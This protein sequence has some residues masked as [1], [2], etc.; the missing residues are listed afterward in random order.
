MK[1]GVL[2]T[3]PDTKRVLLVED[4]DADA[5]LVGEYLLVADQNYELERCETL[6]AGRDVVRNQDIDVILFDL[7]LPDASQDESLE[8]ISVF[9]DYA[10]LVV[11]TGHAET[12]T[13]LEAMQCGAEEFLDKDL[14]GADLLARTIEHAIE[15]HEMRHQARHDWLTDLPNRLSFRRSL[16][17]AVDQWEES[18]GLANFAVVYVD[19]DEFKAVN[20]TFGHSGGDQILRKVAERLGSVFRGAD[21]LARVGGDE[22]E[23]L[24][25][26]VSQQNV[27]KVVLSRLTDAFTQP[28]DCRSGEV[29]L[30]ASAGIAHSNILK[31]HSDDDES[32]RVEALFRAADRAMYDGKETKGTVVEVSSAETTRGARWSL[33]EESRFQRGIK[34]NDILP[35]FQPLVSVDHGLGTDRIC[36][37]VEILARWRRPDGSI[38]LP[39]EF[40][41]LA[42][43]SGLLTQLSEQ[44][45]KQTCEVFGQG[46]PASPEIKPPRIFLNLS[47]NQLARIESVSKLIRLAQNHVPQDIEI[48]F[49]VIET[50]LLEHPDLVAALNDAG[51]QVFIDDFGTGYSSFTRLREI[52]VDGLKIDMGFI[53]GIGETAADEAI[54]KAICSL[55]NDLDLE[56][57]AEGV[58]TRQ[59]FDFLREHACH[60]A[61]GYLIDAPGPPAEIDCTVDRAS[62]N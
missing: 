53:H 51:F 15:R 61:Q 49:E 52:P 43:R 9:H 62:V 41:S 23:L 13:Q 10:P 47:P 1:N 42:E 54:V 22:F 36:R 14:L 29:H 50:A 35:H 7:G 59:Q 57:I 27:E 18:G 48:C 34:N 40:I 32:T 31:T 56:V 12:S 20:D 16:G 38:A 25:K 46:Q 24:L 11:L 2:S 44:L 8:S 60:C 6:S 21:Q 45:L 33:D 26:G 30:T 17:A 55:G 39:G 5:D 37:G 58:E 4:N 3:N 19:I 28:F